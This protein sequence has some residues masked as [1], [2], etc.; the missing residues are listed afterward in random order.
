MKAYYHS[1]IRSSNGQGN[2]TVDY[3]SMTFCV[4]SMFYS[5]ACNNKS[6]NYTKGNQLKNRCVSTDSQRNLEESHKYRAT[7][8]IIDLQKECTAKFPKVHVYHKGTPQYNLLVEKLTAVGAVN[9][10]DLKNRKPF[11]QPKIGICDCHINEEARV[12]LKDKKGN[13][14]VSLDLNRL[15]L[16]TPKDI[17][18]RLKS[19]RQTPYKRAADSQADLA[20]ALK[21][22]HQDATDELNRV[23]AEHAELR[24]AF[25]Q[26]Q[27][28]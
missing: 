10:D 12:T 18:E 15:V 6:I 11:D 4:W 19:G 5:C 16:I 27:H 2:E 22:V 7:G 26:S 1:S 24:A 21:K 23:L 9:L 14:V 20:P 13:V 25:E 8:V 3:E 28:R 17:V